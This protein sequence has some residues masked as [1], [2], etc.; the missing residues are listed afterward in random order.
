MFYADAN[1]GVP[2][3]W[4]PSWDQFEQGPGDFNQ[5]HRLIVDGSMQLPFATQVSF[6]TTAASGLP[7]NPIT[8][9]DNNGDSYAVD[10]PIGFDRNSFRGPAQVSVDV[11]AVKRL[12]LGA[13]LRA[14]ARLEVFNVLNRAN[15]IKVNNIYGE[16]PLPMPTFL[17]PVAG[18]TN[19]D[20]SRQVQFS[21]KLIF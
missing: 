9:R 1:S 11:A 18:I 15:F 4:W 6:V 7:V 8:G 13:R 2:N 20:P 10:R 14:E 5:P 16:G 3:E 17:A 21:A 19:A 12:P